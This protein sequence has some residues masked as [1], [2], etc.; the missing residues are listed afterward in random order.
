MHP[1]QAISQR[2]TQLWHRPSVHKKGQISFK[3][4]TNTPVHKVGYASL[5]LD[6]SAV[7]TIPVRA[8]SSRNFPPWLF[9]NHIG[10]AGLATDSFPP[11]K[12][13]IMWHKSIMDEKRC[14][15]ALSCVKPHSLPEEHKD[16]EEENR[17]W[18]VIRFVCM[19]A[20]VSV[21]SL[22]DYSS[23]AALPG[24]ER[25]SSTFLTSPFFWC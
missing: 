5:S 3:L 1:L 24:P 25:S 20:Y 21:F 16:E 18:R 14:T 6:F 22:S 23:A 10:P 19:P 2:A 7:C 15:E 9:W 8:R 4:V 17:E 11:Y 13:L 12:S